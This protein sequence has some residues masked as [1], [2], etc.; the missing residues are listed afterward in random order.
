M[1]NLHE[2][3]ALN[4][5][6]SGKDEVLFPDGFPGQLVQ[7]DESLMFY[8]LAIGGF[9]TCVLKLYVSCDQQQIALFQL[10][11]NTSSKGLYRT[12][13]QSFS[14]RAFQK[15][16]LVKSQLSAVVMMAT[17]TMHCLE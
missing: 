15:N 1:A 3:V 11:Q 9:R 8:F 16:A 14:S 13:L 10:R 4:K 6:L 7:N 2:F 17:C 5:V 12:L